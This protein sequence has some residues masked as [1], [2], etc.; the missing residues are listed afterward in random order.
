MLHDSSFFSGNFTSAKKYIICYQFLFIQ[1]GETKTVSA[2]ASPDLIRTVLRMVCPSHPPAKEINRNVCMQYH[3]DTCYRDV[4]CTIGGMCCYDGCVYTCT[5][6]VL[7]YV[8]GMMI[9][10]N[11][12]FPAC[13]LMVE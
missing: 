5:Q 13:L 1:N 7:K 8:K 11:H 9:V 6:P 2:N 4:D 3:H 12:F 10:N